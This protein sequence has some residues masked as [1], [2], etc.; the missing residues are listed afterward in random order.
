MTEKYSPMIQQYLKVKEQ[1]PDVLLFYRVGD[2]YEMF[3]EDAK[4]ASRELDLILTGKNAGVKDRIPMCGVPHHAVSSY[5]Q[6]LVQRG[7]K[8]AICEQLQ[9]PKEAQGLVERDVIRV[10]TPGTV[11]EEISDEKASVYLAAVQDYGYGYALAVTEVSTGENFVEDIEHKDSTLL[12]T[13]LRTNVREVVLAKDFRERIIRSLREH[14]VVISYCND[15]RIR[16]EYLPLT[17]GLLKDYELQAYGRMLNYLEAT[18]KHLLA[19][20][21]PATVEREEEV[22]RMDYATRLNLEL[23]APLHDTGKAITLWSFLDECRSAMGSRE[24]RRRIEKPL[25]D[26]VQIESRLDQVQWLMKNFASRR[27]IREAMSEIYDLQR[28][29]ARCAM[30]TANAVDCQRLSKTLAQVPVIL[31]AADDDVFSAYRG[32]DPLQDLYQLLKDAFVDDPPLQISD[33]GMFRDGYNAELDEAREIQRS[34][35]TYIA[36]LEAKERERT[37]IRTLKIGYNKVFGYYI[38]ISKAAAQQVQDDWGY[39]RKQTLTNSERFISEELKE[40]EDAILHAEENAIRI[41]KQLFQNILDEIRKYLVRLQKLAK[42]LAELDCTAALAEVSSAHNYVRPQFGADEFLVKSGRHPILDAIMK[43][44]RYVANDIHMNDEE[45]ILLITGPNMGGKSTY[46][47]QTALIVI[48]A[49]MGC[50]VP[51]RSCLMPLFD[52][53]FTRIGA[54]DDILSGQSTFMVEM[55]EANHALQDATENSLILFDEIGRG[56]STYDGMALAQA[57]IEYIAACVHAKTMFSTH[58]H[59]L[60]S[61]SDSIGCVR[62]VHVAVREDN[63]EVTF[64]YRIKEGPAGHSYGIN[65]ARLA[66]LPDSVLARAHDLQKELESKKRVVQQSYQLVEMKKENKEAEE[67]IDALESVSPDDLSPREAW[68]MLNDLK[69]KAKKAKE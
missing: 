50:F 54:S 28:L 39:V 48:M 69:E 38:E 19:H 53:I 30:N 25:V 12:Q 2:F 33:G 11:M 42:V 35:K 43:D 32:I 56:T 20:L 29:I 14:Q 67:I 44:P 49:Q 6:R 59:E 1:Y 4:I 58:Y 21:Q 68:V 26:R 22:L 36:S 24:L 5:V 23:T 27:K 9:D 55:T 15:I 16:N 13:L 47:R 37:G 17:E 45:R 61:L 52:Q 51:A 40:K 3:M 62:N 8:I 57:M 65:V 60:T 7:Y 66:G 64:M 46:M 10:I 41:E 63:N 18:Q 31:A 34:G